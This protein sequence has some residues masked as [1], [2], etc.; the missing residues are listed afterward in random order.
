MI[1]TSVGPRLQRRHFHLEVESCHGAK[2]GKK[3]DQRPLGL[4]SACADHARSSKA[5]RDARQQGACFAERA[6]WSSIS[7]SAARNRPGA[8]RRAITYPRHKP[9]GD[10]SRPI[11]TRR[12]A[13]P[14]AVLRAIELMAT[15]VRRVR[16]GARY[17]RA[18]AA[19][20]AVAWRRLEDRYVALQR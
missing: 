7:R 15:F 4:W 18:A 2:R 19:I 12:P 5:L 3:P 9:I 8:T 20:Q 13:R 1:S 16:R 14:L 10:A 11:R 17:R 6:R